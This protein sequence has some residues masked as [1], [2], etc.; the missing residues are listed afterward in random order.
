MIRIVELAGDDPPSVRERLYVAVHEILIV[1]TDFTARWISRIVSLERPEFVDQPVSLRTVIVR[2]HRHILSQDHVT[3]AVLV[4][5]A[6]HAGHGHG[7][8]AARELPQQFVAAAERVRRAGCAL[9]NQGVLE[10]DPVN[11]SIGETGALPDMKFVAVSV[12]R[13]QALIALA[14]LV[15]RVEIHDQVEL[16][17]CSVRY[18]R[19]GIGVV[20]A[21]FVQYRQ[22]LAMA[23]GVRG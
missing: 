1:Q 18:P 6:R 15:E 2:Q 12:A 19:V 13:A 17:V 21:R 9:R 11:D 10:L 23:G 14:R 16:V 22:C 8:S 5:R 4:V 20:R 3:L 7:L